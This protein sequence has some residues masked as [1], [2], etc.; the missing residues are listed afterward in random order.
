MTRR[1]LSLIKAH[2]GSIGRMTAVGGAAFA[3]V[4]STE[5]GD[6][7][8]GDGRCPAGETCD[9]TTPDGLLFEGAPL[10]YWPDLTAHTIAT[11]GRQT[12]RIT[13]NATHDPLALP[14]QA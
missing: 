12:Y 5:A 1:S 2:L 14:F 4:A 6:R 9:P 8:G 7:A 10:G 13:D 11:G 3:L